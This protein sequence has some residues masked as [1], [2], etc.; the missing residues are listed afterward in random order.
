MIE[1]ILQRQS[2]AS[3]SLGPVLDFELSEAG[4]VLGVDG[5][6]HKA[7]H[8][9]DRSDL[10]EKGTGSL[11]HGLAAAGVRMR[12]DDKRLDPIPAQPSQ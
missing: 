3:L 5:D 11:F 9:S 2:P 12:P 8:V 1:A 6:E 4:K 10:E 7:V